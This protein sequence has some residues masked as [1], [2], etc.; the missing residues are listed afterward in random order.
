YSPNEVSWNSATPS[1]ATIDDTG[2]A[3]GAAAGTCTITGK[4][5]P[6][7]PINGATVLT[8]NKKVQT[9]TFGALADKTYGDA[10]FTVSA[11]SDSGL[12]VSFLASGNCTVSGT[13]VHITG[14]GSC[15]ITA[16]QAGNATFDA[17]TDVPQTFNIA[18]AHLSVKAD[19]KSKTYDGAVFT[20]FTATI[21]G[22]VNGENSG[23][24]SGS[25]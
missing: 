11:T 10:D 16:Q 1:V 19:D 17:A 18:K 9:I 15:T 14:A 3:T 6:F 25:P 22:F 23:V 4:N 7:S 2:L 24:V 8:V 12:T 13:T 5:I 21:T 20:A